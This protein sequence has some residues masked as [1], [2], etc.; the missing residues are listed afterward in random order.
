MF[1]CQ[2]AARRKRTTHE[3]EPLK[4]SNKFVCMKGEASANQR[5][6]VARRRSLRP[7]GRGVIVLDRGLCFCKR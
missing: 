1:G 5:V 3:Q 6:V 4:S 2:K 7:E